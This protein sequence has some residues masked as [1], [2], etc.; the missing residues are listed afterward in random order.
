MQL[1]VSQINNDIRFEE[2]AE[3]NKTKR[4]SMIET[5]ES[6]NVDKNVLN[7]LKS[8]INGD[9]KKTP[10]SLSSIQNLKSG[11]EPIHPDNDSPSG[12]FLNVEDVAID[13]NIISDDSKHVE[14]EVVQEPDDISLLTSE[15]ETKTKTSDAVAI[16]E[17]KPK[18]K[19]TPRKK[20]N[21][22]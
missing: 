9:G 12:V 19:Y 1:F 14:N 18:R 22:T 7:E 6:D 3:I 17:T 13:E 15:S 11:F 4:K 10:N 2:S 20:K 21:D 5:F 16:P 8:S